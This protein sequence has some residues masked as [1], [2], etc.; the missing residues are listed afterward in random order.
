MMKT[1]IK[2]Y[3][4]TLNQADSAIMQ[5]LLE[6]EGII[7]AKSPEDAD[8]VIVNTC[9]VKKVTEQKIN[10]LLDNLTKRG[11][12]VVVAGCMASANPNIVK[13]YAPKASI[14]ST[15]N[16]DRIGEAV[17]SAHNGSGIVY[18]Q[19]RELDKLEFFDHKNGVIARIPVS[20]GC[21]SSCSFCET[22]F[23]RGALN[24]FSEQLILK[25][26]QNS[27]RNGAMEIQLTSQDMGAY[28]HDKGTNIAK[29]M[30][31]IAEIDGDFKVRIGMLNPDH[32]GAYMDELIE[33]FQG[34]R[35]Y[36]FLHLPVQS[37]S[38]KVIK[39]MKRRCTAETFAGYAK[40]LRDEIGGMSIETDII[41][42]YPTE[43]ENDF[44]ETLRFLNE[45]RPDM[46]NMSRF[47]VREHASASGLRQLDRSVINRRSIELSREVRQ[48]QNSI[49]SHYI[50]RRIRALMTEQGRVSLNGKTDSYKQVVLRHNNSEGAINIGSYADLEVYKTSANALY[51]NPVS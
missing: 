19:G 2:T 50:G 39:S 26:I 29:L 11:A 25:A 47:A 3:G 17:I 45:V 37:G 21:L 4:C 43:T 8:V 1:Y 33:A 12:K 13:R 41:V 14:V 35:F 32:V 46:T 40:R 5:S 24:S 6:Q 48:I 31:K 44:E 34:G 36:R 23:A 42:G 28:G 27:V 30:R 15:Q 49:N 51:C 18:D 38:D 10:Y 7:T 9:T 20:E 16:I 22:K